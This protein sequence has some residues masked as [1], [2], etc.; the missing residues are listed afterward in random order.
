MQ[1]TYSKFAI[2]VAALVVVAGLTIVIRGDVALKQRAGFPQDWSHSHLIFANPGSFTQA[3]RNGSVAQWY[4][5]MTDPRYQIQQSRRNAPTMQRNVARLRPTPPKPASPQPEPFTKDWN[6]SLQ[7]TGT[8]GGVAALRY[9]AKYSF[10]ET[11]ASCTNDF[12]VYGLYS[13]LG[14]STQANLIGV[15]NLYVGAA[16]GGGCGT[17]TNNGGAGTNPTPQVKWAFNVGTGYAIYTSTVLSLDG[18]KVAYIVSTNPAVLQVLTLGS[19]TVGNTCGSAVCSV[20]NPASP[21]NATEAPGSSLVSVTLTNGTVDAASAPYLD[22]ANDTAYVG[23]DA[24]HLFK[25]TGVFLGTPTLA[26]N[27]YWATAGT[28]TLGSP[29]YD[30]TTGTVFVGSYDGKIYAIKAS[31]GSAIGSVQLQGGPYGLYLSPPIVDA[32]NHVLYQFYGGNSGGSAGVAQVVFTSSPTLSASSTSSLAT[33]GTNLAAL[34]STSPNY[35]NITTGAFSHSYFSGFS[36][37]TSF[38]YACG[39]Y[40]T[41]TTGT[42]GVSLQQFTFNAGPILSGTVNKVAEVD[43]TTTGSQISTVGSAGLCSPMTEFYNTQTNTDYLFFSNPAA[44]TPN[45]WAFNITNNSTNSAG[46]PPYGIPAPTTSGTVSD[47]TSGIVV[48][49]A[50]PT[51]NASSLYFTSR[52]GTGG[53]CTTNGGTNPASPTNTGIGTVTA[54]NCAYKLTQSGLD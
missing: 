22:Y 2:A 1:R 23:D 25:I 30:G 40:G 7:S 8:N 26:G 28:S 32:T 54:A 43:D 46:T 17:I 35:F 38:L 24:G 18:T 41:G 31:D 36:T 53:S 34:V 37:S 4:K 12:V 33:A 49:G 50:D 39:A 15:N 47:G 13:A 45:V 5:I 29:V 42:V 11:G 44:T 51:T 16:G 9:P 6:F 21:G 52:T 10:N 19:G 27:T 48:D 20:A 3:V 14:S